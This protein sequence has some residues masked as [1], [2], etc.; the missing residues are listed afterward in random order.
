MR[1][2]LLHKASA[3]VILASRT[4]LLHPADVVPVVLEWASFT[5]RLGQASQISHLGVVSKSLGC[6]K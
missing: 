1:E 2:R 3:A 6:R 4:V 5:M